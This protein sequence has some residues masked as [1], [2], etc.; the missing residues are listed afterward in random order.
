MSG[1]RYVVDTNIAVYLLRGDETVIDLIHRTATEEHR[2]QSPEVETL[3]KVKFIL[4]YFSVIFILMSLSTTSTAQDSIKQKNIF[5][6]LSTNGISFGISETLEGYNNFEGGIKTGTA[7]A[8]TFD[9]NINF[10]LQKSIGI[11]NAVIYADLEYHAG[12]DPSEKLIGDFQVFDKHNS[13]PFVQM[14]E[15]W[16]Q[17]ELFNSKLRLKIGKIDTNS[18]FSVIDNGL[19]FINSS[20]QVTPTFFVFPTF[21]DPVPSINIFISSGKLFYINLAMDYANQNARFLN[22]HGDPV[23]LQP[24]TNGVLLLSEL[25]LKWNHLSSLQKDGNL[26][27]GVWQHTGTFSNFDGKSVQGTNGIY[28]IFDQTLW[29]PIAHNTSDRGIRMFLVYGLTDHHL[30]AVY[31]HYGG[32]VVWTGPSAKRSD[33][34]FGFSS[35]YAFLSPELHLPEQD[36]TNLEAFYKFVVTHWL[37]VKAD[38]QYVINPGGEFNNALVGTMILNFEF[39]S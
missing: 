33:D 26:K 34:A 29:Q 31:A 2:P 12:D 13:F 6:I 22:F 20:T 4:K 9:A 39:G 19:E 11:K 10:D 32:G 23:S 18:E 28:A 3:R 37:N 5:T 27:F 15:F 24:T 36:E 35:H 8:S 14:L 1:T 17:Q 7:Y 21:P 16:Y 25:G 38:A 30:A